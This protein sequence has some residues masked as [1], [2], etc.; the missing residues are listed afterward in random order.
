M[1]T[2][3]KMACVHKHV[4]GER[5][6]ASVPMATVKNFFLRPWSLSFAEDAK[7]GEVGR[8]PATH[9]YKSHFGSFLDR[10]F[11]SHRECL[12]VKFDMTKVEPEK[13]IYDIADFSTGYV[14]GQNKAIIIL[15]IL[16]MLADL[17]TWPKNAKKCGTV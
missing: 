17:V 16:G 10:G 13:G 6:L 4:S 11:E 9:A 14:D 2:F 12:E 1:D 15:S 8:W 5:V 7:Y 3:F